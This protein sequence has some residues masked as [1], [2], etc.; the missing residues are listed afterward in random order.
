M[1]LAHTPGIGGNLWLSWTLDPTAL[2]GIAVF[3]AAYVYGIGPLRRRYGLA[4]EVTYGQVALFLAGTAVFALALISP[5][6]TLGD[7]YLFSAHMVQHM[8]I[9]VVV[10]PLWL[11]GTPEWL[12]APL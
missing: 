6:D 12:L 5:L 11:L 7:D 8:L 9:T 10:A 2:L 3:T 4:P 1:V